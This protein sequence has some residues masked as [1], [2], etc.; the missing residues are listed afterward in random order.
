MR[1]IIDLTGIKFGM[2]SVLKQSGRD[3]YGKILWKCQCDCG[4]IKD[5]VGNNLRSGNLRSC[6]CLYHKHENLVGRVFGRWT[7]LEENGQDKNGNYLWLCKCECGNSKTVSGSLLKNNQSKS[8]GCYNKERSKEVHGKKDG[9][10]S[11]NRLFGSYKR[12]AKSR[13]LDF[14]LSKEL[15]LN[16]VKSNCFYCNC[17]PHSSVNNI[18]STGNFIYNGIDRIDNS[19]GYFE[20]NVVPCCE[21]C[22]RAKLKQSFND[23][24]IWIKEVYEN[25][26]NKGFYE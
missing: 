19:L 13:D 2:L 17:E 21:K 15:F 22:N 9:E 26:K 24:N 8:C 14:E 11:F 23:F 6:G 10:S 7:V 18:Y 4:N 20:Y 12:C 25:L 16:L 3:K 5:C 1:E